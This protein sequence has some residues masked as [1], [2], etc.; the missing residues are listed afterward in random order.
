MC[1]IIFS[2]QPDAKKPLLVVANRDEFYDRPTLQVHFWEDSPDILAGRDQLAGGSWLGI[3]QSGRFAAVTNVREWPVKSGGLSR[4]GLVSGYLNGQ[5]SPL[6]Y[7]SDVESKGK[8]Y[9]GF[10]L[11]IGDTNGLYYFSN[12]SEGIK[13]LKPGIH[14][15]SNHLLNSPWPKVIKTRNSIEGLLKPDNSADP[16]LLMK[17]MQ[18]SQKAPDHTLPD[19]GVGLERERFLSSP[20]I[21]SED[22]GTRNTSVLSFSQDGCVEW[23]EQTYLDHGQFDE[24]KIISTKSISKE[25]TL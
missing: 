8:F 9:A 5:Q 21:A 17:V 15:L 18:D 20:F 13:T 3:N 16:E 12:R 4:G 10:N 2:W 11:L 22:Y 25:T 23:V 19:T 6:D 1:L 24:V 14:G 7:L